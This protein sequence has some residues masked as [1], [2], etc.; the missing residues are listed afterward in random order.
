[1]AFVVTSVW[2]SI[3]HELR[4]QKIEEKMNSTG[5]KHKR[6]KSQLKQLS[7]W[8]NPNGS[9]NISHQML[10]ETQKRRMFKHLHS[11][12]PTARRSW[13]QLPTWGV[14]GVSSKPS[15]LPQCN[16]KHMLMFWH[17]AKLQETLFCLPATNK[18]HRKL[19]KVQKSGIAKLSKALN[20]VKIASFV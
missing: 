10:A 6:E 5:H 9:V 18:I 8:V 15:S 7:H 13:I 2:W 4:T 11:S 14:V 1:M 20:A 19:H 12:V 3:S 16:D 17:M